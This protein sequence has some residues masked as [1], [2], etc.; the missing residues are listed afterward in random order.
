MQFNFNF[1]CSLKT[2]LMMPSTWATYM[3]WARRMFRTVAWRMTSMAMGLQATRPTFPRRPAMVRHR[4]RQPQ[5]QRRYQ[6]DL[7]EI[8]LASEEW[9]RRVETFHSWW[10]HAGFF[11]N[12]C[13]LSLLINQDSWNT[14]ASDYKCCSKGGFIVY[15]E[16]NLSI[17]LKN[18]FPR[19]FKI[20]VAS[21]TTHEVY[22]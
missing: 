16:F 15:G 1:R 7:V 12:R 17:Y 21:N 14:S 3:G 13:M 20:T 9:H 19:T 22:T 10:W 4:R 8:L 6:V 18:T 11:V 5:R 2:I